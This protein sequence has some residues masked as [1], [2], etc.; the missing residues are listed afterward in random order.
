MIT[1]FASKLRQRALYPQESPESTKAPS[2]SKQLTQKTKATDKSKEVLDFLNKLRE[3][4][5]LGEKEATK[6]IY[7]ISKSPLNR[8]KDLLFAKS[9][10]YR[11]ENVSGDGNCPFSLFDVGSKKK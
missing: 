10:I 8:P 5:I 3:N 1:G 4:L 7:K 9:D 6:S 2:D 11:V